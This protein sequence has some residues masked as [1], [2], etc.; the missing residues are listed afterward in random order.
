M[1]DK[2]ID[3]KAKS[4]GKETKTV[5]ANFIEK[6]KLVKHKISIAWFDFY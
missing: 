3:V 4:N 5:P 1:C 2:I 6:T